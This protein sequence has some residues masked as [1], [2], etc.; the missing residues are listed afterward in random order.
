MLS[1]C[2]FTMLLTFPILA[3]V[4]T[5]YGTLV[6]FA[7]AVLLFRAPASRSAVTA[8]GSGIGFGYSIKEAELR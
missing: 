8:L 4:K 6:G 3:L 2:S 7:T 1:L 5:G